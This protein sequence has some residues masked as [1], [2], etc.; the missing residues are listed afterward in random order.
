MLGIVALRCAVKSP[1]TFQLHLDKGVGVKRD[2][3]ESPIVTAEVLSSGQV[4]LIQLLLDKGFHIEIPSRY[5]LYAPTI[6][7]YAA[8]ETRHARFLVQAWHYSDR[9]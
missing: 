8:R 7:E 3:V 4:M 2:T 6:L 1:A 9:S 5:H